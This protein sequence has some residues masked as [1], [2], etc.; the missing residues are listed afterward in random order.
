MRYALFNRWVA[1]ITSRILAPRA[2]IEPVSGSRPGSR[3]CVPAAIET[4]SV[5][6]AIC[7]AL[8]SESE[9][10]PEPGFWPGLPEVSL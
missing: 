2:N 9:I 8:D 6:R 7:I 10:I 5:S 4:Q 1:Q 3:T